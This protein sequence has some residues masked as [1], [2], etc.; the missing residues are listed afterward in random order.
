[1]QWLALLG[2]CSELVLINK[3]PFGFVHISQMLH[4]ISKCAP[5]QHIYQHKYNVNSALTLLVLTDNIVGS[6]HL[7][8]PDVKPTPTNLVV[9]MSHVTPNAQLV[10]ADTKLRIVYCNKS[11]LCQTFYT[12]RGLLCLSLFQ[13]YAPF[14]YSRASGFGRPA[15]LD[16]K[17]GRLYK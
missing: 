15:T 14:G 7:G 5:S 4:Y 3:A 2:S 8:P 16:E 10:A 1:M 9:P 6:V 11:H 12:H 13:R 17:W